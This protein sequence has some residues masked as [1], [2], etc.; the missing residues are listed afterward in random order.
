MDLVGKYIKFKENLGN[1]QDIQVYNWADI[2]WE[3][4]QPE[5]DI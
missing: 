2:F 4:S 3:T 5:Q 1:L